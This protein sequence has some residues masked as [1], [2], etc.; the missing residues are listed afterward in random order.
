MGRTPIDDMNEYPDVENCYEEG[1]SFFRVNRS[2]NGIEPASEFRC[3]NTEMAGKI[4]RDKEC[5]F[6]N[7][8]LVVYTDR[9]KELKYKIPKMEKV[10]EWIEENGGKYGKK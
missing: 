7:K 8:M 1:C 3:I 5:P 9:E 2:D 6:S 10:K 4:L